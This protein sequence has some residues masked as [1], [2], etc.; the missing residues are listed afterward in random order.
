MRTPAG[1]ECMYFYGDYY[2][3]REREECRLLADASPPLAWRRDLCTTCPVPDILLSNACPHL[4]LIPRL[5]RP[6]P[7]IK[8]Q[9]RVV[10]SCDLSNRA[11]FDP[12]IG[13]GQCHPLPPEFTGDF[14]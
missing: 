5:E 14:S 3:G 11:G 8:Q 6:F 13:C 10:A 1:K 7:F 12:H 2:R 4:H 9:V